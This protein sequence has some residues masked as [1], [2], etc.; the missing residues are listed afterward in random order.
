MADVFCMCCTCV[1]TSLS[2]SETAATAA[3][4]APKMS[5][6]LPSHLAGE[7][8]AYSRS[9]RRVF[10]NSTEKTGSTSYVCPPIEDALSVLGGACPFM[11]NR[12]YETHPVEQAAPV[13]SVERRENPWAAPT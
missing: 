1:R 5:Q 11:A 7:V 2:A 13:S 10:G 12:V 8:T 9:L 4:P 6:S 3:T